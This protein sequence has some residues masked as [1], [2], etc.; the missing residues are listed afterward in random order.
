MW[1]AQ[2]RI[3][4]L[5]TQIT[6]TPQILKRKTSSIVNLASSNLR[7]LSIYQYLRNVRI[8]SIHQYLRNVR[9]LRILRVLLFHQY[10]RNVCF[11]R[12]L[13]SHLFGIICVFCVFYQVIFLAKFAYFIKFLDICVTY[14]FCVVTWLLV[15]SI[16]SLFAYFA[17]FAYFAW[18]I[19]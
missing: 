2:P 1:I 10:L 15:L 12:F 4:V 9:I 17:H 3:C 6:Q 13:S 5:Y 16:Y 19:N 11:L 8:L 14:K 7:V 18:L